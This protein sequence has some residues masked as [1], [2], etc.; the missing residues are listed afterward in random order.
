MRCGSPSGKPA[1][2]SCAGGDRLP[3]RGAILRSPGIDMGAQAPA[4][5]KNTHTYACKV[6]APGRLCAS[7]R[8]FPGAGQPSGPVLK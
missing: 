3:P 4:T 5:T 2:H 8:K 7:H 6:S 1:G